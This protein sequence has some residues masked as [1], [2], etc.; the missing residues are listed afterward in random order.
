MFVSFHDKNSFQINLNRFK[1]YFLSLPLNWKIHYSCSSS[2]HCL[3]SYVF[4]FPSSLFKVN[5]I[6]LFD[7]QTTEAAIQSW[8]P[9]PITWRTQT[10]YF[11]PQNQ[12]QVR[13]QAAHSMRPW[14]GWARL[15]PPASARP[16]C[17]W[18]TPARGG[19]E[20]PWALLRGKLTEALPW[21]RRSTS[22]WMRGCLAAMVTSQ[23]SMWSAWRALPHPRAQP[24]C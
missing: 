21:V 15:P 24:I 19:E 20:R 7:C 8:V 3:L 18:A 14:R 10:E 5:V 11:P 12:V 22:T 16:K 9:I 17:A 6:S 4:N 1:K 2:L 13:Y 23:D